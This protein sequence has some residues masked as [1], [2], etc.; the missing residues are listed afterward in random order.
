MPHITNETV[1]AK[2]K[3]IKAAFPTWKFSI[4]KHNYTSIIVDILEGDINLLEGNE[5][6]RGGI[7]VNLDNYKHNPEAMKALQEIAD[8]LVDGKKEEHYDGDYGSIP[9]FYVRLHIGQWNRPFKFVPKVEKVVI[10][11]VAKQIV[12]APNVQAG[13]VAILNY[14]EKAIALVGDTKPVKE[15]IKE[16]G[17]RFNRFLTC[18][19]GWILPKTREAK[20][21]EALSPLCKV[22][23]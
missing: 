23:G 20:V 12:V 7:S 17:G 8:I 16:L 18:G 19:A 13:E 5:D 15:T 9:N 11:K 22:I 14:S 21:R 1:E 6:E 4:T 2:R 3:A 10:E